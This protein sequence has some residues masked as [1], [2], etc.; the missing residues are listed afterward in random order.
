MHRLVSTS[1]RNFSIIDQPSPGRLNQIMARSFSMEEPF[2]LPVSKRACNRTK[3]VLIRSPFKKYRVNRRVKEQN[4]CS[5]FSIRNLEFLPLIEEEDVE[6]HYS[7]KRP[8]P[9]PSQDYLLSVPPAGYQP[10]GIQVLARH[11][12]RTLNSHDYDQRI[13]RIWHIAKQQNMLTAFGEQLRADTEVFIEANNQIGW[14]QESPRRQRSAIVCFSLRRGE[15]T[16]LGRD[17]HQGLGARLYSRLQT[18]FHHRSAISVI[19]SG[20]KRAIDSAEEFLRGV[21]HATP[22][23]H[24]VQE[25]PNKNL[26]YFHKCCPNYFTFK[27][28]NTEIKTKLESIKNAEQTRHFA[29]QILQ[30]IFQE[31]FVEL[32]IQG[33]FQDEQDENIDR[34]STRN[35]V[36][37]VLCL[38]LMF[39]IAPAHSSPYLTKLLAKY[40]N[41]EQSNW[42]AYVNDAQVLVHFFDSRED[43]WVTICFMNR[44][45]TSKVPR[46]KE[47]QWPM[48]WR[49]HYWLSSSRRSRPVLERVK[50]TRWPFVFGLLMQKLS[51]HLPRCCRF[52]VCRTSR[53]IPLTCTPTR[54]TRGEEIE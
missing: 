39:V 47:L 8:Y 38:Y 49:H 2:D 24:V 19:T 45:S 16:Q 13:L 54:R 22:A 14:V 3:S 42:F 46:L 44:N 41:R 28:T 20:K 31:E 6:R 21:T 4:Q 10:I 48:T 27:S 35:E 15:L 51:F 18:L 25:M 33:H 50:W 11:G 30:K 9:R 29:R 52:L 26:L 53:P 34:T 36:D 5:T 37:F 17:E 32:L 23:L 43:R 40:F 7:T 12:S 1:L